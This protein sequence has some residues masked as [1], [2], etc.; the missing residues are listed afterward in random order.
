[1]VRAT[2][3]DLIQ[4]AMVER[5]KAGLGKLVKDVAT[6]GGEFDDELAD[7]VRKFPAAWVAF[8]GIQET[9]RMNTSRNKYLARGRFTVMVGQRSVRS[10]SAARSGAR[11][12][13]GSNQLIYA[14]RRLLT[15]QDFG[16]DD[17][18]QME[19][20][21]VRPI[22]NGRAKSDASSVY[23]IE[24]DVKWVEQV[25]ENG[26]WP[27]P[28]PGQVDDPQAKDPDLIFPE[29]GGKTDTPYPWLSSIQL[30]YRLDGRS[31]TDPPDATDVVSF[32]EE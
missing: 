29:A 5:L 1:M 28:D 7:V 31:D 22:F 26:R 3:I 12:E 17:V 6:Y 11:G 14:V 18:G 4:A 30:D 19:P 23:A 13:V 9:K 25:L 8:L 32:N 2:V 27:S 10:E 24:F 21:A 16:L 15:G 20:G